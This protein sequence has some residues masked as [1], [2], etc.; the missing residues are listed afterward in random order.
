MRESL[1]TTKVIRQWT[2]LSKEV[3][4]SQSSED[5]KTQVDKTLTNLVL[6]HT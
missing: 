2:R 3:V 4:Q 1:S 6:S 5:L